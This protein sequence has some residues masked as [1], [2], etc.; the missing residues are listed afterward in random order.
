MGQ[1]VGGDYRSPVIVVVVFK[2]GL[3]NLPNIL[4][5]CFLVASCDASTLF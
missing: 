5:Y 3:Y 1:R 2:V 4:L